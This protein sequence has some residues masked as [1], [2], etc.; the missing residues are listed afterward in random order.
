MD[1]P[2]RV[3]PNAPDRDGLQGRAFHA[4]AQRALE[5]SCIFFGV[6]SEP[7]ACASCSSPAARRDQPGNAATKISATK[8]STSIV[9]TRE[10]STGHGN[11]VCS[12]RSVSPGDNHCFSLDRVC[13]IDFT[14]GYSARGNDRPTR[15]GSNCG[16]RL[17]TSHWMQPVTVHQLWFV[18]RLMP[19]FTSPTAGTNDTVASNYSLPT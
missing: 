9:P 19:F 16:R 1:A 8:T 5:A 15:T 6:A 13:V 18:R 14:D 17:S 3:A 12:W 7:Y 11:I 4:P 10:Q 2:R